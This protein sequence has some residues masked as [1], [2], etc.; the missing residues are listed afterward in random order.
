MKW[1]E[2]GN[3]RF[4]LPSWDKILNFF[5]FIFGLTT[6]WVFLYKW[7]RDATVRLFAVILGTYIII[8]AAVTV[9]REIVY[10]RKARYAEAMTKFHKAM[11]CLRDAHSAVQRNEESHS[12]KCTEECLSFFAS[13]FSLITGVHCRSCIKTIACQG[14]EN[15]DSSYYVRTFARG[16]TTPSSPRIEPKC[17]TEEDW[18]I[19]NSDLLTLFKTKDNKFFS[20][21]LA[22]ESGY[23]NSHWPNDPRERE[24]F[25]KNEEYDYIS[26]IVWPIR[27]IYAE[28]RNQIIAGFLCID[29]KTRGIFTKRYDVEAGAIL[30]DALY[31]FLETYRA[32]FLKKCN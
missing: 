16:S 24:K 8:L 15:K 13:A 4:L 29:S 21:N 7:P 3:I 10:S 23:Q 6:T 14:D 32:K 1:P 12:R 27:D 22:K 26:T 9:W 30:A 28:Q 25:N 11:H 17:Y 18:I 5:S 19:S 20:N 2:A 31:P